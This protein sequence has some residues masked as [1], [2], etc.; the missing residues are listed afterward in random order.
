MIYRKVNKGILTYCTWRQDIY[1]RKTFILISEITNLGDE[2]GFYFWKCSRQRTQVGHLTSPFLTGFAYK[3]KVIVLWMFRNIM[4]TDYLT[5]F[6]VL[7]LKSI[8][9]ILFPLYYFPFPPHKCLRRVFQVTTWKLCA[10]PKFLS[11][12][13]WVFP[14]LRHF[15]HCLCISQ[16]LCHGGILWALLMP[17]G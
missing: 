3:M 14:F 10:V 6:K 16:V 9:K 8:I 7:T 1:K 5:I 15:L 12:F 13:D 2:I 11:H 4:L 17:E